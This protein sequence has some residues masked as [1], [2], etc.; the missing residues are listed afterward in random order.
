MKHKKMQIIVCFVL[1]IFW[2]FGNSEKTRVYA[3]TE[4][5]YD[6]YNYDYREYIHYTPAPYKPDKMIT[7]DKF[8]LDG[9]TIGNFVSP[10]DICKGLSGEIYVADSGNNRIVVLNPEMTE[11]LEVIT[12]FDNKGEEDTFSQ[13]YGVFVSEKGNLYIADY[14][15]KRVLELDENRRVVLEIKDPKSESFEKGFT[16]RPKKVAVDYADRVYVVAEGKTE[17]I[18]V[19]DTE[20]NFTSF[21]G[22]IGVEISVWQKFWRRIATKEERANQKLFIATE[23]TGIDIDSEG[24]VYATNI[25]SEGVQGVRRI[26]PKGEDVIKKGENK[27]VGGDLHTEGGSDYAGVSQFT[28]VVY[29][30]HGIYSCLDRKRGRIF[31]YDHEGNLLYIFGGLGTQEG[32]FA[33]PVAVEEIEGGLAV[34]D[35]T[36]AGIIC[37]KVSEYGELINTAV[38]YRFDGDETQAVDLWRRVLEIDENNEL[39]NSG[40]GKA[41]LTAGDYKSAMK[42]LKLAMNRDYYSIAYK[43][44]RNEILKKYASL[45]LSLIFILLVGIRVYKKVRAGKK[46]ASVDE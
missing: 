38:A 34:L 24:F 46:G 23:F 39:A 14:M 16:F 25:D 30:E 7:G 20:G 37:F 40:I 33:F 1:M 9:E 15:N 45:I 26:N 42:Y 10:Q 2:V 31:T 41:Y 27:N 19:F 44:Y 12:T 11:V 21:F 32:T 22:T 3:V 4:L 29:R 8:E 18:M 6:S 36:R 35:A 13:P 5:P 28:D 43:R 17:G